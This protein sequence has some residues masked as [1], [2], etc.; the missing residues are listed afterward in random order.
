MPV[1]YRVGKAGAIQLFGEHIEDAHC[2][3]GNDSGRVTIRAV[4]ESQ[5]FV[6]GKQ[7]MDVIELRTGDRI[8]LGDNHVLKF[9]HPEQ[10]E[11]VCVCVCVCV[12]MCVCACACACACACVRVRVCVCVCVC[13]CVHVCV[14]VCVCVP[15]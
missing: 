2:V 13:V 15:V 6:N 7:V 3:L 11:C 12:Y 4:N 1:L 14:C 8:I 5:T 10:S 9:R